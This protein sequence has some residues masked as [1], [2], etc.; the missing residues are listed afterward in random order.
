MIK[1]RNCKKGNACKVLSILL[2]LTISFV[3][4]YTLINISQISME[5]IVFSSLSF[6]VLIYMFSLYTCFNLKGLLNY[7]EDI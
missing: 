5:L 1:G 7:H 6:S 2:S 4:V 3:L